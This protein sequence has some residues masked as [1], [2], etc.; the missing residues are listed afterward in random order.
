[1]KGPAVRPKETSVAR[2]EET[3]SGCSNAVGRFLEN[4]GTR[5]A[6]KPIDAP[7][8][9]LLHNWLT[10]AASGW[11]LRAMANLSTLMGVGR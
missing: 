11:T 8:F 6:V 3:M 4:L 9:I 5:G 1:M 2:L 10:K 7:C